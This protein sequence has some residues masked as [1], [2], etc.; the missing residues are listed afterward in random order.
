MA[1]CFENSSESHPN[2]QKAGPTGIPIA[3]LGGTIFASDWPLFDAVEAAGGAIVLNATEPGERCLPPPVPIPDHRLDVD[4]LANHYFD[5]I[6]DVFRRPNSQLYS[7][8][9]PR[10]KERQVRGIIL[11]VR[12]GCDL[13]RA[14]AASLRE[15]FG[16]PVLVL[17]SHRVG[18]LTTGPAG[19]RDV[20]RLTAFV[21]S[22]Q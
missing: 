15:A 20:T 8:L 5:N 13:W 2:L 18:G 14:E 12:V 10:L 9:E 17:D 1:R 19:L 3:L 16:L 22:L 7:W 21:E 11:P 6:V 4:G